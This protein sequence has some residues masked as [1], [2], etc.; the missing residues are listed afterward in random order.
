[1]VVMPAAGPM[2]THFFPSRAAGTFSDAF[3]DGFA[4][5]LYRPRA[6]RG[7]FSLNGE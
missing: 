4:T 3:L 6:E 2:A 1:M 7:A 5:V